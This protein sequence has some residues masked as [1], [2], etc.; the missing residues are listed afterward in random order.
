MSLGQA[1]AHTVCSPFLHDQLHGVL[2]DAHLPTRLASA[3]GVLSTVQES[4]AED[5]GPQG[6]GAVD[7]CHPK[8]A[9]FLT[10]PQAGPKEATGIPEDPRMSSFIQQTLIEQLSCAAIFLGTEGTAENKTR[11]LIL[12]GGW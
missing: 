5:G 7:I 10:A 12:G 1:G 8:V 6:D 11:S 3:P 4:G 2:G 9:H